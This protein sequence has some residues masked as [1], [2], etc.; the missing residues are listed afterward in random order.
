MRTRVVTSNG[1]NAET[2]SPTSLPVEGNCYLT[3]RLYASVRDEVTLSSSI[4]GFARNISPSGSRA[5]SESRPVVLPDPMTWAAAPKLFFWEGDRAE[6]I[7]G[8][9]PYVPLAVKRS[10]FSI[11]GSEYSK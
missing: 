5:P 4:S 6:A 3:P 2:G 9:L 7:R 10:R 1:S 8:T 11:A